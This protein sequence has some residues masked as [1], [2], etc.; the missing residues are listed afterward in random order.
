MSALETLITGLFS[1]IDAG[2]DALARLL[3]DDDEPLGG[4]PA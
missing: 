2:V 3:G 1:L 4:L